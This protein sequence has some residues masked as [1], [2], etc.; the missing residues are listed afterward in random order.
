MMA[1]YNDR[2]D[3]FMPDDLWHIEESKDEVQDRKRI[4]T[5]G[6]DH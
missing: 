4:H 6:E 1:I 2:V 5:H 3:K